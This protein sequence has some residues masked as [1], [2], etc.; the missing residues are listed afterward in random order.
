MKLS[1][2]GIQN[3][4]VALILLAFSTL[5][6]WAQLV[7]EPDSIENLLEKEAH[8]DLESERAVSP[9]EELIE[10]L[11]SSTDF[12]SFVDSMALEIKISDIYNSLY[13]RVDTIGLDYLPFKYALVGYIRLRNEGMLENEDIL[14][15]IDYTKPSKFRRFYCIDL[16]NLEILF[17]TYVSH[18]KNT[19]G[20]KAIKFSNTAESLQSSM[21][22]YITGETYRGSKGFSLRLDGVEKGIN[23]NMRAR[24]VVMHSAPYVSQDFIQKYGRLGRSYGCPVVPVE[25]H[26]E[27]INTIKN[28]SAVFGYY[29]DDRYLQQ[30][31]FIQMRSLLKN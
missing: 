2:F 24:A 8:D 11:N 20:D 15:I 7:S 18:G 31:T 30:S 19:G 13:P 10:S 12:T 5:N 26:K 9:V 22:L 1:V 17:H 27:I 28:K 29:N 16:V 25:L 4:L 21:G 6:S 14:S 23:D 3:F